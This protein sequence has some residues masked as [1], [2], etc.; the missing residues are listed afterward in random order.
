MSN[1]FVVQRPSSWNNGRWEDKFDLA[2][3]GEFGTIIPIFPPG[4]ISQHFSD[5]VRHVQEMLAHYRFQPDEDF[6]LP[7]GDPTAMVLVTSLSLLHNDNRWVRLLK[8]DG[9]DRGYRVVTLD[10]RNS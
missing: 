4:N 6:V 8:W 10:I 5:H 2:P 9:R 3:A 7:L 1:V